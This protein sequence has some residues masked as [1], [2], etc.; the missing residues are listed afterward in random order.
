[1]E[2]YENAPEVGEDPREEELGN[3][4]DN[5]SDEYDEVEGDEHAVSD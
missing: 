4:S 5:S 1:M 2:A 3:F